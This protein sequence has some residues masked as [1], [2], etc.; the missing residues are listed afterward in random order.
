MTE[1]MTKL[2]HSVTEDIPLEGDVKKYNLVIFSPEDGFKTGDHVTVIGMDEFNK[3]EEDSENQINE[4]NN[5]KKIINKFESEDEDILKLKD[6]ANKSEEKD[7][8]ISKL[9]KD[10]SVLSEKTKKLEKENTELSSELDNKNEEIEGLRTQIEKLNIEVQEEYLPKETS[11]SEELFKLQN[12]VNERNEL[13]FEVTDNINQTMEDAIL[14]TV[15]ETNNLINANNK[16]TRAKIN[17]TVSKTEREVT[18][19]NRAVASNINNMVDEI[20]E[21]LRNISFWKLLFN[22]KDIDIKIPTSDLNKQ[23]KIDIPKNIVEDKKVNVDVLKIKNQHK[24]DNLKQLW[25]E[26]D[27]KGSDKD[28]IDVEHQTK[29][30]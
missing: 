13:L 6:L 12:K 3:L 21:E 23:V 22:R 1:Y 2:I 10:L 29:K 24:I 25:I 16:T 8:E 27:N 17:N 4:I 7:D 20:N 11:Q 15:E 9:K 19:R 30:D 28:P 5:L 18:E 14:D 26:T